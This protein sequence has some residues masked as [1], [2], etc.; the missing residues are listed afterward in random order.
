MKARNQQIVPLSKALV[1]IMEDYLEHRSGDLTAPL[2]AGVWQPDDI[3]FA[4]QCDLEL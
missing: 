3:E 4:R 2:F 1:R